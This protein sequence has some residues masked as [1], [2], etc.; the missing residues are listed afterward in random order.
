M[1]KIN[2]PEIDKTQLNK[3]FIIIIF[4][5]ALILGSFL[6]VFRP[7]LK[8]IRDYRQR[9]DSIEEKIAAAK[10]KIARKPKLLAEIEEIKE[11]LAQYEK[12]L[13]RE[14]DIPVLLE[15]LTEIVELAEIEFVSI[16]PKETSP[17][18][19][20]VGKKEE[21][22]YLR[23]PIEIKMRCSFH[24]LEKFLFRLENTRRF[25]KVVD[26]EIKG[27]ADEEKGHEVGLTIEVYMYQEAVPSA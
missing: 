9:A 5:L 21:G 3:L 19:E 18:E 11:I 26:I 4:L 2:I 20:L 1:L 6:G 23:L 14:K 13:P 16:R 15:E 27:S 24:D 12:K 7:Q 10:A 22:L 8:K 17:I 25:V